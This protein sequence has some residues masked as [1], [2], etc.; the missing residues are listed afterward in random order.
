[1]KNQKN[2]LVI[3]ACLYWNPILLLYRLPLVV[4]SLFAMGVPACNSGMKM[5]ATSANFLFKKRKS[6][7][8]SLFLINGAEIIRTLQNREKCYQSSHALTE[9]KNW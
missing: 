5:L 7:W 8:V 6:P 4:S 2:N 3:F 9:D 1:M